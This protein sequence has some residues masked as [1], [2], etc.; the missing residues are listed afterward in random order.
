MVLHDS[1]RGITEDFELCDP[2]Y[3]RRYQEGE[4]PPPN[5]EHEARLVGIGTLYHWIDIPLAELIYYANK[6][7]IKTEES[8]E[9]IWGNELN[10]FISFRT[11]DDVEWFLDCC[12]HHVYDEQFEFIYPEWTSSPGKKEMMGF[13]GF[14][15][16]NLCLSMKTNPFYNAEDGE[17]EL[18]G[19]PSLEFR[20]EFLPMMTE[21][22]KL[23]VKE[24]E[25]HTQEML[26]DTDAIYQDLDALLNVGEKPWKWWQD[27]EED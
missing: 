14:L 9:D 25:E 11:L 23:R 22:M 3:W 18:D 6:A 2:F 12:F 4:V 26:L 13:N 7:D 21:G 20:A 27:R 1:F 10:A 17:W 16:N 19:D 15:A 8:C 24:L 5:Y